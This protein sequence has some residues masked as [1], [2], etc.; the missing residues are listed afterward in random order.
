M[1]IDPF[2]LLQ[3]LVSPRPPVSVEYHMSVCASL[4]TVGLNLQLSDRRERLA[5][6]SR[7]LQPA[8]HR[9]DRVHQRAGRGHPPQLRP[10]YMPSVGATIEARALCHLAGEVG[11]IR[12]ASACGWAR[13]TIDRRG[14]HLFYHC[15]VA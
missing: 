8:L 15:D 11:L 2:D 4:F 14:S 6:G 13:M 1:L 9:S 12:S 10:R 7:G 5:R 3:R